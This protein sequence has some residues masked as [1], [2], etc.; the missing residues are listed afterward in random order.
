LI[1]QGTTDYEVGWLIESFS[2]AGVV[3]EPFE[4]SSRRKT[5]MRKIAESIDARR[6][7]IVM[8]EWDDDESAHWLLVIGYQGYETSDEGLQITHLLCLDPSSESPKV[9]LWN[10]VI[11]VFTEDGQTVNA[12]RYYCRHWGPSAPPTDCRIGDGVMVSLSPKHEANFF[13]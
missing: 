13:E 11:E 3:A 10:A 8:V 1:T 5:T 12:G 9:S 4:I 7:P 6:V 2:R